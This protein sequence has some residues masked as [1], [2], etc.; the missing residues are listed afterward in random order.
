MEFRVSRFHLDICLLTLF[1][2]QKFIS[3]IE[4][5]PNVLTGQDHMS[6]VFD[7]FTSELHMNFFSENA[8][9]QAPNMSRFH[10]F[11]TTFPYEVWAD[12]TRFEYLDKEK[13]ALLDNI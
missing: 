5:I 6:W 10:S 4:A 9:L 13:Y 7:Y 11:I 1:I 8:S 3:D 12:G 2:V